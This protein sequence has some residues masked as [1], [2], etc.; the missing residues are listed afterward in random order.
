[1]YSEGVADLG[2]MIMFLPLCPPDQKDAKVAQIKERTTNRYFSAFE[3]VSGLFGI[4]GTEIKG[5][6]KIVLGIARALT[7]TSVSLS[8]Y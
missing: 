7:F 5:Q 1:M 6:R 2:E 3:K 8:E 4:F